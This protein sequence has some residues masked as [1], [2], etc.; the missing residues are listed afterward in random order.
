MAETVDELT[1][2]YSEDGREVV[3]ELDKE[4]LTKGAW[5]TLMFKYQDMDK[6]TGEYGPT[7]VTIRR[8]KKMGGSY[9]PQSKFN[10]SGEKQAKQIADV[11][12]RWF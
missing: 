1:V 12:N 9:R 2:S 4:V 5:A 7:K 3:K 11:L 6:A 8:Y 10:I